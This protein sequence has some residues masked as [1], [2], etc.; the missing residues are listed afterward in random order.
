M[1]SGRVV[2]SRTAREK[3]GSSLA[4][5]RTCFETADCANMTVA[6]AIGRRPEPPAA[7]LGVTVRTWRKLLVS[8]TVSNVA[9]KRLGL[10]AGRNAKRSL[11]RPP[12]AQYNSRLYVRVNATYQAFQARSWNL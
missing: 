8:V 11:R 7:P 2:H 12:I 1:N 9:V 6:D 10:R 3:S 5:A 4:D